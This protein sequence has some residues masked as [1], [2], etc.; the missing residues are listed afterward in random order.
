MNGVF[1]FAYIVF[2]TECACDDINDIGSGDGEM[3]C[4]GACSVGM[5]VLNKFSISVMVAVLKW[6]CGSMV[7]EFGSGENGLK[8]LMFPVS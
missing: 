2:L 1:G 3:T 4:G 7:C 5:W 8:V 6:G